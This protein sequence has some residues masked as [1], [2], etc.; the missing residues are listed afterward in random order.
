MSLI[1]LNVF[2]FSLTK[3]NIYSNT[4]PYLTFRLPVSVK[5]PLFHIIV[6]CNLNPI[7]LKCKACLN[8]FPVSLPFIVESPTT[9]TTIPPSLV[10]L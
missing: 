6:S 9:H 4:F 3:I 1:A 2:N 10:I 7:S 8:E 5:L